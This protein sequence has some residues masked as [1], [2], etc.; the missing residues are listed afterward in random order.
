[1]IGYPVLH[2]RGATRGFSPRAI[3][4]SLAK[5][6]KAMP[7]SSLATSRNVPSRQW[8]CAFRRLVSTLELSAD[9]GQTHVQSVLWGPFPF[10]QRPQRTGDANVE[11]GDFS[12]NLIL[13]LH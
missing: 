9:G 13:K 5:R 2:C 7:G 12:T 3:L 10:T 11:T 6:E 8:E 1:M 4:S